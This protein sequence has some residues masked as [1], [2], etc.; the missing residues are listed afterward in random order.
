MKEIY[1]EV[2]I[3]ASAEKV[4]QALID[5]AAYPQWNPFIQISGEP[6]AGEKVELDVRFSRFKRMRVYPLLTKIEWGR[7]LR[8][9]G[10]LPLPGLFDGEHV[11]R[12]EPIG[13][14]S[15]K[16]IQQESYSGFLVPVMLPLLYTASLR[17]FERMNEA[18]KRYVESI[19]SGK[20]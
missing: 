17:G 13:A 19:Q 15:V 18:L 20:L 11:F 7:E 1:T 12:I 14:G 3:Q 8:W 6:Q 9:I 16:L 2:V 10:R 5:F 4:W